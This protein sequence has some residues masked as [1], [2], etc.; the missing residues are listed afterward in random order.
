M[1]ERDA[2][3]R[4]VG[5]GHAVMK[6]VIPYIP[7]EVDEFEAMA[8]KFK[9]GDLDP[10]EFRVFRL[11]RG[12]YGQRQ[13]GVQMYRI[14]IPYGRL[15]AEQ[16]EALGIICRDF[17]PLGRGHFTTRENLQLHFVKLEDT[18][19]IMRILGEAGLTSREA[20]GNTVRN[21]AG[22]PMAGVCPTEAFD[23]SPY[24]AAFARYFVRQEF[25]QNLPR[26]FK[27]AFSGCQS[28]CAMTAIHDLGFIAQVRQENGTARKGFKMVVGGG[29]SIMPRLAP[30]LYE[31]VPVEEYL[32]ISEAILR[33]FNKSDE[34]RVNRMKA[35]IKFLVD[36]IGA[37]AFRKLVEEELKEEW[38]KREYPLDILAEVD[39]E[40]VDAPTAAASF[41]PARGE[42]AEFSRWRET[43]VRDQ[44]QQGFVAA[45]VTLTL[46]N[47]T[48]EQ[49]FKLAEIT[50][51]YAGGRCRVMQRQNLVLRW[52]RQE[53][54]HDLY[55]ALNKIGL[56]DPDAGHLSDVVSCPG[57]ES[58]SLGI[59]TSMGLA[60]HLKKYLVG[61]DY[62]DPLVKQIRINISGCPDG[63]GQHNTGNIGFQGA[64]MRNNGAQIPAY[65]VFI[66][67][68]QTNGVRL[69]RQLKARCPSKQI[70]AAVKGFVDFYVKQRREG[71]TF[72]QFVDRLGLEPFEQIVAPLGQLPKLGPDSIKYYMDWNRTVLYQ[73][74]RGEGECSI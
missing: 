73:V 60:E 13:P 39:D 7:E 10:L 68:S 50:R 47:V 19:Q 29:L 70:P 9:A 32:R 66:G 53:S 46:G 42:D 20:C 56:A 36:R 34:L 67:G 21:V 43:N 69:G 6:E 62:Q 5:N 54:V 49:F 25:D 63:C 57:T 31:F 51:Q 17:T 3:V 30:V 11:R 14:K 71:E 16:L 18:P 37:D 35:R 58:C 2:K 8:K 48:W 1:T 33:V 28:D 44:K 26:K 38:A 65:E 74:Q 15:T 72:N 59:T 24:A 40:E 27:T 55:L 61:L 41:T 45:Q 12:V 52:V 22:C 64:A 23:T 4:F